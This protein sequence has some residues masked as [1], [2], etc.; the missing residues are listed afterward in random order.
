MDKK[1]EEEE[2][3]TATPTVNRTAELI[4]WLK[5]EWSYTSNPFLFFPCVDRDYFNFARLYLT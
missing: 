2:G 1:R 4:L 3:K 5:N